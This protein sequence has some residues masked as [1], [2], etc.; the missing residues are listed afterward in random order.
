MKPATIRLL[1]A[2]LAA[3]AMACKPPCD[4]T[5]P[6]PV[7]LLIDTDS[8]LNPGD[9]G[10]PWPVGYS[11]YQLS[12]RPPEEAL[13][14]PEALADDP[15]LL[16]ATLIDVRKR[17][18]HPERPERSLVELDPKA[19]YILVV[20][21]FRTIIGDSWYRLYSVPNE[22]RQ[23]AC[24]AARKK[25][26]LADPC[27]YIAFDTYEVRGGQTPPGRAAAAFQTECADPGGSAPR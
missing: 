17:T 8:S 25:R 2:P 12:A 3:A 9:K 1:L 7:Q 15:S 21:R 23:R 10:E 18:A 11:I 27:I 24:E 16:G 19:K 26:E 20:A 13:A 5:T 14:S 22:H 6:L 4:T